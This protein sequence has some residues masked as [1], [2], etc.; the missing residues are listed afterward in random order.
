MNSLFFFGIA[1]LALLPYWLQK[2][3]LVG[4]AFDK[5]YEGNHFHLPIFWHLSDGSIV[6]LI[7]AIMLCLHV[8]DRL[9]RSRGGAFSTWL[10]TAAPIIFLLYCFTIYRPIVYKAIG[11]LAEA[12]E[13]L[14]LGDLLDAN[15]V[16]G[17]VGNLD[18]GFIVVVTVLLIFVSLRYWKR[19]SDAVAT[20]FT[21]LMPVTVLVGAVMLFNSAASFAILGFP[22]RI[23]VET[24]GIVE[25]SESIAKTRVLWIIFDALDRLHAFDERHPS[26]EMPHFDAFKKHS[27]SFDSARS[28][29]GGTLLSISS[30][31]LGT[32]VAEI[33]PKPDQLMYRREPGQQVHS[34]A[35]SD[36]IF[37]SLASKKYASAA[38]AQ[39]LEMD[40]IA[41]PYCR[42]FGKYLARCWNGNQWAPVSVNI[43][44]NAVTI[45]G[46][47]GA[48]AAP[49]ILG[50]ATVRQRTVRGG[51]R[52]YE[53][54]V[55]AFTDAMLDPGIDFAFV[56]F[57][58]PHPPY[59][60]DREGNRF[61]LDDTV[62]PT[63]I[64]GYLGNLEL[65]DRTLGQILAKLRASGLDRKTAIVVT[66][67]HGLG[68]MEIPLL[69]YLPGE[70]GGHRDG[71]MPDAARL[72]GVV[73]ALLDGTATT[74]R[75]IVRILRPRREGAGG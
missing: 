45:L 50:P 56:H 16:P 58:H 63:D 67:D 8:G 1:S 30:Y 34:L 65:A 40:Q 27:L 70:S 14:G 46:Q 52:A 17:F 31:L 24:R 68:S 49:K 71:Q 72:R 35:T 62:E 64:E 41:L 26:V 33:I 32:S 20:L 28:P 53:A 55:G 9:T 39:A 54:V 57:E 4:S 75:D 61:A 59:I 15:A 10:R 18:T 19:V 47:L 29:K 36:T 6:L 11:R 66:A 51:T 74:Y 73:E 60:Y 5:Q 69:V 42:M 44:E 37:R 22:T 7:I 23:N 21:R 3:A 2:I 48:N 12:D 43:F 25:G 38:V 13:G